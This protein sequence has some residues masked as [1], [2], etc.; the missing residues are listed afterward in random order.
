MGLG[1]QDAGILLIDEPVEVLVADVVGLLVGDLA[2]AQGEIPEQPVVN[3]SATNPRIAIIATAQQGQL[4]REQRVEL[5]LEGEDTRGERPV[6]PAARAKADRRV[7]GVREGFI[8]QQHVEVGEL[9][10]DEQQRVVRRIE[11][12]GRRALDAELLAA[13]EHRLVGLNEADAVQ[14]GGAA[15]ER[16]GSF[17]TRPHLDQHAGIG[18]DRRGMEVRRPRVERIQA[19]NDPL[20][21]AF[22]QR[23]ARFAE[24]RR[25]TQPVAPQRRRTQPHGV[26]AIAADEP[27]VAQREQTGFAT[28][29]DG[30]VV[31]PRAGD[32]VSEPAASVGDGASQRIDGRQQGRVELGGVGLVVPLELHL[33]GR[34]A[35]VAAVPHRH[36]LVKDIV[37]GENLHIPGVR[38][39]VHAND[40]QPH[41][42]AGQSGIVV[43]R[44]RDEARRDGRGRGRCH[45]A[46]QIS[47][48]SADE[49]IG[50]GVNKARG[51]G[52]VIES[53]VNAQ[54]GLEPV[55]RLVHLRAN[56]VPGQRDVPQLEFV[57]LA[58]HPLGQPEAAGVPDSGC[59]MRRDQN[60]VE[61]QHQIGSGANHRVVMPVRVERLR[62]LMHDAGTRRAVAEQDASGGR[63]G[64]QEQSTSGRRGIG[65]ERT[66]VVRAELCP[67]ADGEVGIEI[68][69]TLHLH[70]G[71][72]GIAER[73]FRIRL[74][75]RDV[76][77]GSGQGFRSIAELLEHHAAG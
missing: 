76:G 48:T 17:V 35:E 24:A 32:R 3:R 39:V 20:D 62:N 16:D 47:A 4:L 5:V 74:G 44:Q 10:G 28:F 75:R 19:A 42:Q 65:E 68:R 70:P 56:P 27:I 64:T 33:L 31:D 55:Q 14:I 11:V 59:G 43:F 73:Q 25:I 67:D 2:F 15:V 29:T 36:A 37:P 30:D 52:A 41:R 54:A 53:E 45:D 9:A 51:A 18:V 66:G 60:P 13:F 34:P 21:P 12:D 40:M 7:L 69:K 58:D 49:A 23:G 72:A 38:P 1:I 63:L 46:A 8:A 57:H 6:F 77:Q 71:T 26:T 61:I 50:R 22:D